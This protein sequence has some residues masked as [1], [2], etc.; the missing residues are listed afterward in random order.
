L[1][2]GV[3]VVVALVVLGV[4]LVSIVELEEPEVLAEPATLDSV[5]L[6]G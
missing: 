1:G 3:V 2:G 5:R 4:V 6:G